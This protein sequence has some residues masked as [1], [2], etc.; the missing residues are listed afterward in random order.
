MLLNILQNPIETILFILALIVAITFHEFSHAWTANKLGDPT[1]K[2]Q[3]RISLNPLA[4]LDP[5]GSIF[6]LI[7]GFGWGKPVI[8]DPRHYRRP[9]IDFAITSLAGPAA[10]LILAF[11][12]SLPGT[13]AI[14]LGYNIDNNVI[15]QFTEILLNAN[16]LLL[17]FNLLPIYPLDGS[18]LVMALIKNPV[19]LRR[20]MI[21]GPRLLFILLIIHIWY[22]ILWWLFIFVFGIFQYLL[23]GL[24]VSIFT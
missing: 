18:K 16:L 8:T 9:A 3:G 2:L 24:P 11:F 23:R 13:M 4:H 21:W 22:P 15:I 12:S 17:I 10:N 20:Y 14:I 5:V 19:S 7:A 1:P 6:L